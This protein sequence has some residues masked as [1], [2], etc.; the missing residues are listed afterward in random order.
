MFDKA[1]FGQVLK[2]I[3]ETYDSQREFS[4]KSG[5]N[6]TYLSQYMNMK[7]DEP[8]KPKILE[9]LANASHGI[10]NY[11]I[12]ME[13]CGYI[14]TSSDNS[15]LALYDELKNLDDTYNKLESNLNNQEYSIFHDSFSQL[16]K[17]LHD[18]HTTPET[19]DPYIILNDYDFISN[20][21]KQKLYDAFKSRFTYFYKKH[22]IENKVNKSRDY[23]KN[24][25][26]TSIIEYPYD[27]NISKHY[28]MCPVYGQ[29]S[30]G[31]PNW[32]EE[33][34]EGRL[35][36]DPE[37]MGIINPEEHYF[38]RVNG[39]SMNKIVKN[40]AFALIHKQDTVENGEIAVVLVNGDSAT[41]KRFSKEGD[42][43]V[44]TPESTDESIKQQIYTKDTPVKVIGKYVGKMELN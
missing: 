12:L 41:L 8:P 31:Q 38:L 33:C 36:I 4:K 20:K 13:I 16:L 26:Q 9:K 43:I 7:L 27:N 39:E 19:F 2:N 24:N 25:L 40:G 5:I 15:I 42:I 10:T 35:P 1:K 30:A 34:I 14:E 37:L 21:S 32:A 17:F 11:N 22:K 29:I 44:L 18:G 23:N 6:R 3:T 28:Y